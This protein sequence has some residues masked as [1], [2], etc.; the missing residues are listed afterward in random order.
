MMRVR[1]VSEAISKVSEM[2]G[3]TVRRVRVEIIR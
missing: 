3:V 2:N 1:V